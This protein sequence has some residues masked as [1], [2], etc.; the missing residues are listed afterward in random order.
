ME[1]N[2]EQL[3]M[4]QPQKMYAVTT[5]LETLKIF[6]SEIDAKAYAWDL[7]SESQWREIEVKEVEVV[8]TP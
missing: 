6:S 3:E 8:I 4:I 2:E 5:V 1:S 7:I